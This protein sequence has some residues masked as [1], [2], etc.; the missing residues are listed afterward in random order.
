MATSVPT[1]TVPRKAVAYNATL[2]VN[3][4]ATTGVAMRMP[5]THVYFQAEATGLWTELFD[6]DRPNLHLHGQVDV[7]LSQ[8]I[9]D[10]D[11][12]VRTSRTLQRQQAA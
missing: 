12:V 9:I 1:T 4:I 6:G 10:G 5:D 2:F 3:N 7:V 8:A 11:L